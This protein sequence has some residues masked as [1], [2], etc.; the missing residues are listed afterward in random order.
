[1]QQNCIQIEQLAKRYTSAEEDSLKGVYLNINAGDKYGILG[2]NGAGKTTL[3]SI[4]CGILE[5]SSGRV[6]YWDQENEVSFQHIQS[7]I[8]FVPQEYALYQELTPVQ[9]LEYFGA[10]YNLSAS[11]IAKRTTEIL[12]ILG[13]NHVRN[14][15]VQTFSGGMKRRINLAIGVLHEPSILFLD[16]PT[17]GVDVQSKVAIMKFLN[18]LNAKGTTIIYTSHHLSEAQEFCNEIALI[19]QGRIILQGGME[20]LLT[21]HQAADLKSLFIQFTG[22]EYRD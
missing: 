9:N 8:G 5:A 13:L 10:L 3:I 20:E 15:R 7:K 12:K 2:P 21:T 14:N 11:T 17:V 18:Q 16:E 6:R 4:I 22:E 1:M 19:D